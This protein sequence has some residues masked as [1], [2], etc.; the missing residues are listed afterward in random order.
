[1]DPRYLAGIAAPANTPS[2]S[3]AASLI[4]GRTTGASDYSSIITVSAP[5]YTQAHADIW[6]HQQTFETDFIDFRGKRFELH[7]ERRC[8][9]NLEP[10]DETEF[11]IPKFEEW[12][13]VELVMEVIDNDGDW[14]LIDDDDLVW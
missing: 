1:M 4:K 9:E 11:H 8:F 5:A 12:T 13:V 10:I 6:V 2:I 14:A 7:T 3:P